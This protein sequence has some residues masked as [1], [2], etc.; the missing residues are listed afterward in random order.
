MTKL[1]TVRGIEIRV[2]RDHNPPH[3]H[4][5]GPNGEAQIG[6]ATM[7]A[8]EGSVSGV[9]MRAALK[10]AIACRAALVA[11]WNALNPDKATS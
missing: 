4:L 9:E 2:Y 6:L 11:E 1:G 8:I 10:W 7:K 3:F 5:V